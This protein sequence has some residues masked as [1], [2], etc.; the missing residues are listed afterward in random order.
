VDTDVASR[1]HQW[2][3]DRIDVGV[4]MMGLVDRSLVCRTCRNR[5]ERR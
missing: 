1:E 2:S 5:E 3:A 4:A